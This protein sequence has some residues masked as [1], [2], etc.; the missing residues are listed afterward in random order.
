MGNGYSIYTR[1]KSN[2]IITIKETKV[3]LYKLKEMK[4]NKELFTDEDDI[5]LFLDTDK[6]PTEF[7]LSHLLDLNFVYH[8][9][10]EENVKDLNDLIQAIEKYRDSL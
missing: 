2:R 7:Y 10:K 1:N 4:D 9:N 6:R 3:S 8:D 5:I